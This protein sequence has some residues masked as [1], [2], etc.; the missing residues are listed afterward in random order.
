M[1]QKQA[2]GFFVGVTKN[3]RAVTHNK[4]KDYFFRQWIADMTKT[5]SMQWTSVSGISRNM[6][7]V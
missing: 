4:M 5:K 6:E 1:G 2:Q 3:K 7:E